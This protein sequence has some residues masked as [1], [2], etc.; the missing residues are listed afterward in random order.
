[1]LLYAVVKFLAYS[2]WCYIGISIITGLKPSLRTAVG[3]GM[4]RWLLGMLFGTA[5]FFSFPVTSSANVAS[6][7]FS[8]YT[9]VRIVE[10]GIIAFL[11]FGR[12]QDQ[13][14][15]FST[16]RAIA[17]V[18][19]GIVVSFLTDLVSPEGLAGRFCVGRCF[20]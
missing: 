14:G 8:I 5:I 12:A 6:T 11:I 7:Y 18:I 15:S 4:V 19:G 2:T 13:S 10:W 9:P 3:L 16:L 1:M 17:W 20:C